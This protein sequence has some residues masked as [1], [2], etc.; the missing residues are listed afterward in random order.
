MD[1][2]AGS[3]LSDL[4]LSFCP[5]LSFSIGDM[6][7]PPDVLAATTSPRLFQD[8]YVRWENGFVGA[9][10]REGN[11]AL[12]LKISCVGAGS[13]SAPKREYSAFPGRLRLF[14]RLRCKSGL[15]YTAGANSP[16][17]AYIYVR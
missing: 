14:P 3:Q 16:S 6:T 10:L 17:E 1:Q 2:R 15:C 5:A 12:A 8:D 4:A 11:G 13:A 7:R 9:L